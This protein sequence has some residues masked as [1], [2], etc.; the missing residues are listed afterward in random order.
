MIEE[1]LRG[2]FAR[3]EEQAPALEPLRRA[4][5]ALAARRRR[6]RTATRTGAAAV[7]VALALALPVQLWRGE[8][9]LPAQLGGTGIPVAVPQGPLNLLLLGLDEGGPNS[10]NRSRADTYMLIHLPADGS[11]AYLVSIERD[12]ITDTPGMGKIKIAG[13]YALGGAEGARQAVEQLTGVRA[14][15]VAEV[16]LSAMQSVTDALGGLSVCLPETVKSSHTGKAYPAGCRKYSGTQV[17]DLARQRR[18]LPN[19]AYDRDRIVQRVLLALAK[20]ASD[21]A[22]LSNIGLVNQLVGT[23]GITLHTGDLSV[24]GLAVRL[25]RVEAAGIIGVS[26]PTFLSLQLGNGEIVEQ[27][28]PKVAPDLSAALRDGTMNDFVSKHPSWVLQE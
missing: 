11:Q 14:D 26:Q 9:T 16:K 12:V 15:A 22:L 10:T 20:E 28:D 27:L 6:R 21:R 17:V 7:V 3:H 18:N 24:L 1:E 2:A 5:D 25:D 13:T 23:P 19:G 8:L 4:I